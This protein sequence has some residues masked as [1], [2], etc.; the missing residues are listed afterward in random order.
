M[1]IYLLWFILAFVIAFVA[2][3]RKLGFLGGFFIALILTPIVG[4]IIASLSKKI[5]PKLIEAVNPS[6]GANRPEKPSVADE[7]RKL[8]E[9]HDNGTLTEAE[10]NKQRSKIL[11]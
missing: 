1:V 2:G 6:G 5:K 11:D 9:L 10:Y 3:Q 8:K 7:I 4:F